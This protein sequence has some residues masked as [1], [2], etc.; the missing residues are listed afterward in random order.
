M[1]KEFIIGVFSKEV[2]ERGLATQ[3]KR[4]PTKVDNRIARLTFFRFP[5]AGPLRFPFLL[6]RIFPQLR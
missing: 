5:E 2:G 4:C 6:F 3:K 1:R